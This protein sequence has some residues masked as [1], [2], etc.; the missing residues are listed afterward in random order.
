M[1]TFTPSTGEGMWIGSQILFGAG[2]GFGAQ[3]HMN[4]VQTVL[5]RSDIAVGSAVVTF[6][7]FLGSAIF[8]P[9]GQNVFIHHLV[10]KL[11]NIPGVNVNDVI[12]GGA[13]DLRSLVP[14]G[15]LGFLLSVYSE[16]IVNVFYIVVG[17]CSIT[18]FASVCVEWRSLKAKADAEAGKRQPTSTGS[19][20]S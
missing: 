4:V 5:G 15:S 3:Q 10:S 18:I 20:S 16:A 14:S 19:D 17:T 9:I 13:T 1:T 6:V 12:N 11:T 7:R 8:V 2:I